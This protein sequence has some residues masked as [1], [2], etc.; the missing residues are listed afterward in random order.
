MRIAIDIR[1]MVFS[2]AGIS[3]YTEN[4]I[5]SLAGIDQ[6]NEYVLLS[7]T[8][9]RRD[10]SKFSNVSEKVIRLP[11]VGRF[12]EK[13]WEEALLPV[14]L[15]KADIFHSPR[16]MLPKK[17]VCKYIDTIHD[18]AFKRYPE[19]FTEQTFS[20]VNDWV[21]RAV[22]KADKIIAISNNTKKDLIDLFNAKADRIEVIYLGV[23]HAFCPVDSND[24]L[25]ETRNKYGLPEKFILFVGTIEPRKNLKRLI[26]AF[27]EFRKDASNQ[28]A[29]IIAGG[30][31]WQY[32]EIFKSV[33]K[34]GLDKHVIFLDY[35]PEQDLPLIY[36]AADLFVYPSLYEG[37]GLPVLEAMACGVPVVTSD[38][39]SL[40]EITQ[41]AAVL[42]HPLDTHALAKAMENV[43][44]DRDLMLKMRDKGLKRA[45]Q[46][47][48]SETAKKTLQVYSNV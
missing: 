45:S 11:N 22:K 37:F 29:L 47:C 35:I 12:T 28:H 40:P 24:P 5:R 41:D 16:F 21:E 1:N 9:S 30:R 15:K 31:G 2:R 34:L 27:Y 13:F 42:V 44:K 43:L 8:K 36:N 19:L 20:Y 3:K 7:N 17:K 33:E 6:S 14:E 48:W 32:S 4:L 39:S 23:D 26:E 38:T 25:T 18:L 10:W 46:F